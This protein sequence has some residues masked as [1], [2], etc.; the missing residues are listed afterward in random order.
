M[1]T[2]DFSRLGIRPGMRILDVG[3]GT[4]R[5]LGAAFRTAGIDVVGVDLNRDDLRRAAYTLHLICE[6]MADHGAWLITRADAT[7]LPFDDA[8]F[9]LVICSEVLEH[10]PDNRKAVA[11]LVRVLKPGCDL[12]VSVPRYW[13]E[14]IC[15]ALSDDYWHEPGGHIRIYRKDELTR[16]LVTA[17]TTCWGLDYRHALHVPYWWLKCAVGHKNESSRPVS[18]YRKFLEWDIIKRPLITRWL[19]ALLNPVLSKSIVIYLKKG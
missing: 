1:L 12:V 16:M 5:H 3:C 18:L 8:R 15:W 11:E 7:N 14:R 13:P 19:D 4:G 9:D 10:I 2:V 6:E 17:G